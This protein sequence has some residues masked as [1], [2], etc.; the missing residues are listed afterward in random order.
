MVDKSVYVVTCKGNCLVKFRPVSTR[1]DRAAS[2]ATSGAH[3]VQCSHS[4]STNPSQE[5]LLEGRRECLPRRN[6]SHQLPGQAA[7]T[8]REVPSTHYGGV[9]RDLGPTTRFTHQQMSMPV[10][11]LQMNWI[12][13]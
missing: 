1:A 11:Q 2:E 7:L 12:C 13:Q 10:L 9:R 4:K 3:G 8:E 6:Q 5:E